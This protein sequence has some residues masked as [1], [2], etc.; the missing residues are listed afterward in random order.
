MHGFY[1]VH[2]ADKERWHFHLYGEFINCER[3][4]SY[5]RAPVR[6]EQNNRAR[7]RKY[8]QNR[9]EERTYK[10]CIYLVRT[11]Y[12]AQLNKT[13]LR[14]IKLLNIHDFRNNIFC[15]TKEM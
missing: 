4:W 14:T 13:K 11:E 2:S 8:V 6:I 15:F 10:S 9:S 3:F 7:A 12:G 1:S 5:F